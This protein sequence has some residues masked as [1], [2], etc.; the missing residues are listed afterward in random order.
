MCT[1]ISFTFSAVHMLV[2]PCCNF[3]QMQIKQAG[4]LSLILSSLWGL[5]LC[6]GTTWASL[7]VP[8]TFP[9]PR[10][11]LSLY[12]SFL[13]FSF[14]LSLSGRNV[15]LTA[16]YSSPEKCCCRHTHKHAHTHARASTH[17]HTRMCTHTCARAHT[18]TQLNYIH[19]IYN[20][21]KQ[22]LH[23]CKSGVFSRSVY[24]HLVNG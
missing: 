6:L 11:R 18:Y 15:I 10:R 8:I 20:R 23:V 4:C 22:W 17:A 21:D 1:G 14:L 12:L 19:S 5:C 16:E 2:C 24:S 7:I 9:C 3:H 13:L